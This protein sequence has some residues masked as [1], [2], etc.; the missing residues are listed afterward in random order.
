[1]RIALLFSLLTAFSNIAVAQSYSLSVTNF[2]LAQQGFYTADVARYLQ[3]GAVLTSEKI[4]YSK[5]FCQTHGFQF[6]LDRSKQ[7]V[8]IKIESIRPEVESDPWALNMDFDPQSRD[9]MASFRMV[10]VGPNTITI[11][12]VRSTLLG[13]YELTEK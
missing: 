4:N 1:M 12:D 5:P 6:N 2:R 7:Y 8:V 13:I 10:C 3:N 11:D 9:R